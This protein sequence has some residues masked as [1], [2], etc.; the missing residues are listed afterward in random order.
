MAGSRDG[1]SVHRLRDGVAPEFLAS[2]YTGN[3]ASD[4][5]IS[6]SYSFVANGS[7]GLAV[8]DMSTPA[9]S[10]FVTS[11]VLDGLARGICMVNHFA[12][13][14]GSAGLHVVDVSL[15]RSPV[16]L[17]GLDT[18][19]AATSVVEERDIAYVVDESAG[20]HIVDLRV[21]SAPKAI[22]TFPTGGASTGA[23][24]DDSFMFAVDRNGGLV[25]TRVQC[26]VD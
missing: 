18:P 6:G 20:V 1:V 24:V 3:L 21:L 12:L 25:V 14:A 2:V 9:E 7:G 23:A 22:G 17:S 16:L 10:R 4:V 19:G 26:E 11:L 15:P 8:I 13:V 5:V